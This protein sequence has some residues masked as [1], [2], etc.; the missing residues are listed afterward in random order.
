MRDRD[1]RWS[2]FVS[3]PEFRA[4]VSR[5]EYSDAAIVTRI[6]SMFLRPTSYSQI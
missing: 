3:D 4:L 1:T 2:A 5:P 6:S